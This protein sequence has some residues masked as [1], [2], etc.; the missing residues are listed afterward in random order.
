MTNYPHVTDPLIR[1][2]LDGDISEDAMCYAL[3]ETLEA[4][5][6]DLTH[7]EVPFDVANKRFA[8]AQDASDWWNDEG[9]PFKALECLREAWMT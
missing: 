8:L 1:S 2:V 5:Q 7:P 4:A 9:N 6:K 3:S